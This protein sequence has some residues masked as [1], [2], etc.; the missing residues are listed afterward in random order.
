LLSTAA[1]EAVNLR[2]YFMEDFELVMSLKGSCAMLAH[3]EGADWQVETDPYSGC[4]KQHPPYPYFQRT[5]SAMAGT[6]ALPCNVSFSM[7]LAVRTPTCVDFNIYN[8]VLSWT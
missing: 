2:K 6:L 5:A 8:D 3:T 4:G 7:D 1:P